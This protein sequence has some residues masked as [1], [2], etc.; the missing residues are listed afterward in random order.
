MVSR[1]RPRTDN[2]FGRRLLEARERAGLPQDKVGVMIGLEES[3]SSAR[4]SRYE[5]GMHEPPVAT[6]RR[7]AAALK[8]PLAY[9]Y[10]DD[11]VIAQIL[12]K[13]HALSVAG[14]RRLLESL[15]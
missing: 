10:C 2:V 12:L 5:T 8:V 7:I 14:R 15:D 6:A 9:L 4:M 1:D 3:S 11:D 13:V